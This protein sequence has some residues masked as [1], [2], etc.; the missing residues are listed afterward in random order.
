MNTEWRNIERRINNV[1]P[2]VVEFELIKL[3][4]DKAALLVALKKASGYL[5]IGSDQLIAVKQAIARME[6][7]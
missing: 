7:P 6:K 4:A 2:A 3:R 5:P 1:S